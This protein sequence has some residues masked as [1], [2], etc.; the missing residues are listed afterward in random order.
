MI[1]MAVACEPD[2]IIADE[3]TTALEVTVQ[4]RILGLLRDL[5]SENGTGLIFI[6][7]DLGVV[8]EIANRVMVMYRGEVIE[9]GAVERILSNPG[10]EYT[11]ALLECRPRLDGNPVRLPVVSDLFETTKKEEGHNSKQDLTL[12][13]NVLK[14]QDLS[15]SF[16]LKRT[17]KNSPAFL[18][19]VDGVSFDVRQGE[20]L[21]LVGESGC[22]KSTLGRTIVGLQ[23]AHFGE[24]LYAGKRVAGQN[25]KFPKEFRR[26]I[27]IVFQDP[28]SSLNPGKT[29]EQ[30]LM[31][32]LLVHGLVKSRSERR[33]RVLEAMDLVGLS[34][35]AIAK[36]PHQ[37]SGG[38][39]QRICI[40]RT[41]MVEPEFII[42]D[43]SVSAL[44]VSV[45]AKVLNL[46]N[47][48]KEELKLTYIFISHDLSVVK[49]M[50][51]RI[52]VMRKGKIEEIGESDQ[53]Y[54]NPESAY[55]KTLIESIPTI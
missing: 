18:K 2:L 41:L 30:A 5:C 9:E 10:K 35:D 39:R 55:T 46:L 50:S 24:V 13:P 7:H 26:K 37:F 42:C 45:Q 14:V 28:Y 51:D 22:G 53:I 3:P 4:K 16:P 21:G 29:V 44:D 38:Q 33:K 23:K 20:T 52:I 11:K 1:A 19:A 15:V 27:Q 34:P 54:E 43:E 8:K 36:Y 48:L 49:Y 31:E 17:T 6:T 12:G 32:P 47:D 40:A 25:V